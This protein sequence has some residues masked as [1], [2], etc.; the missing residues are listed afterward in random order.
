MGVFDL[1]MMWRLT[2]KPVLLLGYEPDPALLLRT[3]RLHSPEAQA[4]GKEIRFAGKS[5]LRGPFDVTPEL[6]ARAGLPEGW[7]TAYVAER[8]WRDSGGSPL[9]TLNVVRGLARHLGG[10]ATEPRF[11]PDEILAEVTGSC[12]I[13][14]ERLVE[15]LADTVPGLRLHERDE[16]DESGVFK[17]EAS[18]IWVNVGRWPPSGGRNVTYTVCFDEESTYTP[19]SLLLGERAAL[20]IAEEG[21]G[22]ARDHNEF[23]L[24]SAGNG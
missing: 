10:W 16:E 20:L 22:V 1:R 4:D 19:D 3:L 13:P 9:T 12:A 7:R 18:L 2:Q 24:T 8:P 23:L 5:R 6:L 15:L 11:G 21:G 14:P 17:S